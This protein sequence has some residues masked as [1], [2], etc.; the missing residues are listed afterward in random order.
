[1]TNQDMCITDPQPT[2]TIR[3]AGIQITAPTDLI[4]AAGYTVYAGGDV[5]DPSK[6]GFLT[7]RLIRVLSEQGITSSISGKC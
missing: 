3:I 1:M 4:K 6:G 5:D 7:R 2:F